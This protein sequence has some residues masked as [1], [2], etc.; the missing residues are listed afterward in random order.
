MKFKQNLQINL[1]TYKT[2]K[3]KQLICQKLNNPT[4]KYK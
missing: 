1:P 4:E 3:V 2:Q